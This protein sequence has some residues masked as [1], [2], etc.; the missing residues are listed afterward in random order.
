MKFSM[1]AGLVRSRAPDASTWAMG[2]FGVR[3]LA[4]RLRTRST[5]PRLS[6]P[7]RTPSTSR[8]AEVSSRLPMNETVASRRR[9]GGTARSVTDSGA[10]LPWGI[11]ASAQRTASSGMATWRRSPY[12]ASFTSE[13]GW[14]RTWSRAERTASRTGMAMGFCLSVWGFSGSVRR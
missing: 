8:M 14:L 4:E 6:A 11:W 1:F 2:V 9:P 5:K 12:I 3:A 13:S 7:S 10:F